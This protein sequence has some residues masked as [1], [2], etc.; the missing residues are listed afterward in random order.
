MPIVGSGGAGYYSQGKPVFVGKGRDNTQTRSALNGSTTWNGDE[1]FLEV[2]MTIK[3]TSATLETS[4]TGGMAAG[5]FVY[6]GYQGHFVYL[7]CKKS[8]K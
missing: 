3:D 2:R 7:L 6:S 4:P 8:L 5:Q 1:N